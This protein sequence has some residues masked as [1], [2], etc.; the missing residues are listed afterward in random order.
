MSE[1]TGQQFGNYRLVRLIGKGGFADVYLGEHKYLKTQAAIK[2]MCQRMTTAHKKE[3]AH[4]AQTIVKLKHPHILKIYDFG[5]AD[6]IPYIIMEYAEKGT[7]LKRHPRGVRVPLLSV[8]SYVKQVASALQYAHDNKIIHRDI[9]PENMLLDEQDRVIL[10]DFGLAATAHNTI[11]MQRVDRS[12]TP[13][14]MAPEQFQG[15]PRPASDQYALGIVVYEWLCGERPFNGASP[16]ELGWHHAYDQPPPLSKKN[17]FISAEVEK[18]VLTA[19]AKDP[20]QRFKSIL[21]FAEALEQAGQAA[22]PVKLIMPRQQDP[23]PQLAGTPFLSPGREEATEEHSM[24][25]LAVQPLFRQ[26]MPLASVASMADIPSLDLPDDLEIPPHLQELSPTQL[27]GPEMSPALFKGPELSPSLLKGRELSPSVFKGPE[28]SPALQKPAPRFPHTPWRAAMG[29]E[30]VGTLLCVYRGH[31]SKIHTLSW[32]LD[33]KWIASGS[34]DCFCIWDGRSGKVAFTTPHTGNITAWAPNG[35]HRAMVQYGEL[36]VID[37]QEHQKVHQYIE[38]WIDAMAWSPDSRF[39]ALGGE[40]GK[41]YIWDVI[42][43]QSVITHRSH[44]KGIKSLAWS[45]DGRYIA[46]AG[47]DGLISIW[48]NAPKIRFLA[49][50]ASVVFRGHIA[51]IRGLA[52]SPDG[53]RIVSSSWDNTVQVWDASTAATLVHYRMHSGLV[54]SLSWSPDSKYIAS[55]G[56]DHTVQVW[57]ASSGQI[58]YTYE[59][60]RQDVSNV[61]WS[62]DGTRIAS[63]DT[64]SGDEEGNQV[65]SVQVWQTI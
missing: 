64:F 18:V 44:S 14:Y 7:L 24:Q 38:G 19:L 13:H 25:S 57:D 11:S 59:G 61:A 26:D 17:T 2:I 58:I 39:L 42:N 52:W 65:Y 62:P 1:R 8:V 20:Q 55:G 15:K 63:V 34:M 23:A 46:A 40:S 31:T 51:S 49:R 28:L 30:P 48:D 33:S 21:E 4:E 27:R 6:D 5:F 22:R 43:D 3:F 36:T 32:S 45:P 50:K 35:R 9:K 54:N 12:G 60:H 53:S 16:F 29:E 56:Q 10:S 47:D 37:A 41:V